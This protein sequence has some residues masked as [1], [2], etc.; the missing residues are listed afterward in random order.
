LAQE[1]KGPVNAA[2]GTVAATLH[3]LRAFSVGEIH[4][5]D[6]A[7]PQFSSVQNFSHAEFC[8]HIIEEIFELR[9]RHD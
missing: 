9:Y 2:S 1:L 4:S 3:C 5:I 7:L 8:K 6:D